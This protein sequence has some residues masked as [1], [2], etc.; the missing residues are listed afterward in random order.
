MRGV[1]AFLILWGVLLSRDQVCLSAA[2]KELPSTNDVRGSDVVVPSPHVHIQVYDESAV[3][4]VPNNTV[5]IGTFHA[6]GI[7][8]QQMSAVVT[9]TAELAQEVDGREVSYFELTISVPSLPVAV[10]TCAVS[11][12]EPQS[13]IAIN[14]RYSAS[15]GETVMLPTGYKYVVSVVEEVPAGDLSY[16]RVTLDLLPGQEAAP[17]RRVF[18]PFK[19]GGGL[20]GCFLSFSRV[21]EKR[22]FD[23]QAQEYIDCQVQTPP[24]VVRGNRTVGGVVYVTSIREKCLVPVAD[25]GIVISEIVTPTDLHD[26]WVACDMV[27]LEVRTSIPRRGDKKQNTTEE[28]N[29]LQ[30][31]PEQ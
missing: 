15:V 13:L 2:Q 23:D 6:G 26:G 12:P 28:S 21:T 27:P 25:V 8:G 1:C 14:A 19:R 16:V 4:Q 11:D 5:A 10:A 24:L 30:P 3:G 7:G 20:Y 22:R 31:V 29:S 17:W 9:G 18:V